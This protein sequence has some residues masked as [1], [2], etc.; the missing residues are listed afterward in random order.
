M[1]DS[2]SIERLLAIM[3]KLRN[4]DGGCPW[5]LEQTFESIVP[6]TIEEAYEVAEAIENGDLVS[7]RDELGDLLFQV[8][9]YAQMA[10]EDE[11]YDF[12]DIVEGVCQKMERR[13]PHVF[14]GQTITDS[15]AQT[16]AWEDH[17]AK[18][19]ANKRLKVDVPESVLDGVTVPLPA[20]TRAVKLQKRAAR[21]GFDWEKAED[22][23]EKIAEEANELKDEM[24][25]DAE[26]SRLTDELG[27][28]LFAVTNLAR[29]LDID[30]EQ[31]L[32]GGNMKFERRFRY[33]EN[34]LRERGKSPEDSN[35]SEM[36]S[37]WSQ[38]KET[39]R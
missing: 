6:H 26:K 7:L 14:G 16:V 38:A 27:D 20:M 2:K 4:S 37:L 22:V 5:D 30:P 35:L 17:K 13:H 15:A 8:V 11:L 36:E 29:K 24:D 18:E 28:L 21:V 23:L 3:A 32:R 1:T 10:N 39:E 9:F 12:S 19:R 31:A 33:I 34:R 25:I